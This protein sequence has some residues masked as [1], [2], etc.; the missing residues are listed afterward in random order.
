MNLY[1]IQLLYPDGLQ[2]VFF[3][4]AERLDVARQTAKRDKPGAIGSF[5]QRIYGRVKRW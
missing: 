4:E 2:T 5:S 1:R 3:I